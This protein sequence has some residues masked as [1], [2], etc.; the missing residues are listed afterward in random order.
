VG[1][2]VEQPFHRVSR[3]AIARDARTVAGRA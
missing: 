1:T 3:T 2:Y